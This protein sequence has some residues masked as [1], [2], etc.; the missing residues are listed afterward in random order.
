VRHREE[1][2]SRPGDPAFIGYLDCSD[3]SLAMTIFGRIFEFFSSPL[4]KHK[5]SSSRDQDQGP[6]A[7]N[8]D[9]ACLERRAS[10]P[11]RCQLY[12][13]SG[14]SSKQRGIIEAD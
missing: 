14:L 13:K 8:C 4:A 10:A 1:S 12:V 6:G 2:E 7:L 5:K 11:E 9:P 3:A